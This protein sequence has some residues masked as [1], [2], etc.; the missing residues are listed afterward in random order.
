MADSSALDDIVAI[1]FHVHAVRSDSVPDNEAARAIRADQARRWKSDLVNITL[2]ETANYYR[3]RHMM[4]V[5]FPVDSERAMGDAR[6][7]NLDIIAA[8]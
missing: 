6:I 2:D 7:P 4:A 8:A 3:E 1:D 5:L